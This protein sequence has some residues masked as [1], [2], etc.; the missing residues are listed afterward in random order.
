ML[1]I[2]FN[3]VRLD[4][5]EY[6]TITNRLAHSLP[7]RAVDKK[8]LAN[9]DGAKLVSADY[10]SKEIVIEGHIVAPNRQSMEVARDNLLNYLSVKEAH[11]K[12]DQSGTEREY[13]ATVSQIIFSEAKGGFSTFTIT[14]LCSN[15]FGYNTQS[16]SIA[17][18]AAI[19]AFYGE[20]T[21]NILGSYRATPVITFT[22]SS[23]SG[24]TGKT[25]T[26]TN[27]DS[28]EEIIVTRDWSNSDIL[29]IDSANKTVKVNGTEV[30]YTGKFLTFDPGTGKKVVY[31]DNFT[32]RSVTVGFTYTKRWL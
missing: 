30:N 4:T 28:G 18:G 31:E 7:T 11:L 9:E 10:K 5:I 22:F 23:L 17:M 16:T 12:F 8:D 24:A 15:P 2:Y 3:N 26:I 13:T 29:Q 14:F 20:K 25:V 1:P 27:P 19:I 32:G 21:F 6:I